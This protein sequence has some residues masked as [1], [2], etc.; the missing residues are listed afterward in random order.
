MARLRLFIK[1]LRELGP[2]QLGLY[3]CYQVLLRSGYLRWRTG[4][5]R[6]KTEKLH[7]PSFV[8]SPVLSLPTSAE[9][10]KIIGLDGISE[11]TKLA[12]EI[13]AGK[14]R[15]F[16][17]QPVAITLTPPG[18]LSHWTDYELGRAPWGADDP[19]FIWEPARFGWAFTLGQAY[20]L[21]GDERYP[22]A[23]W[24]FFEK[25]IATNPLN[26]GPNWTS[27]QEVA[28]RILAFVFAAQ[29]FASSEHSTAERMSALA[30]SLADHAERIPPSILY[31]RAQN[32]NHLLSEAVG[33]LTAGL[34]L[35]DHPK[36]E[37][38]QQ[39][40]W[41]WFQRGIQKQIAVDGSYSQHSTNYH[42]LML[43]L[44]L[45][46]RAL[47]INHSA[48]LKAVT[49]K[50]QLATQWLSNLADPIS[51]RVP[52]LGPND[53]AN[54]LPLSTQPFADF[55]PVL[56][57][58]SQAFLGKPAFAPGPWDAM[59]LWFGMN[60]QLPPTSNYQRSPHPDTIR[61]LN[62]NSWAYLRAAQFDGRPGHADQLHL[63]LWWRGLNVAQDAGTYLY[64]SSE[65]PWDN[66][67]TSTAVHNTVTLDGRDQMTRAGRFLFVDRAQAQIL[68]HQRANDDSW[69]RI[70]AQ[71]D[72]YRRFGGIHERTVTA[73]ADGRWVVEDALDPASDKQNQQ[74][75]VARLHWLLPDWKYEFLNDDGLLRILSPKGWISLSVS[76][77]GSSNQFT[78]IRAGKILCGDGEAHPAWGWISP[79]YAHKEP[80]LSFSAVTEAPLP[81]HFRSEW[82]FPE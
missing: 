82:R 49:P 23:F 6:P 72:G 5:G 14:F 39:I 81:I 4:D 71:H 11:L 53:G 2:G 69:D 26:M 43:Q 52:N 56:Q 10:I 24:R 17:G 48:S 45:W 38:W 58:A 15:R 67:L 42:R 29:I 55:R 19:K 34:A 78:L 64:T 18:E 57:A 35:P 33:L 32:N 76:A 75:H 68:S 30:Q 44:A 25:F 7:H 46:V 60:Q 36:S 8:L 20:L 61:N 22:E 31:A 74:I 40:G 41:K 9:I 3:V 79:T 12:D 59:S 13:V 77:L 21:T 50:L 1:A 54:I 63:D 70:I 51:G 37:R 47:K 28:I 80:A 62:S 66:R 73:Y 16:G 65:P 27:A